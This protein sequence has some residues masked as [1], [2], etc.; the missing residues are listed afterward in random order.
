MS[1]PVARV[2]HSTP[3]RSVASLLWVGPWGVD[4]MT[5]FVQHSYDEFCVELVA[6]HCLS[7]SFYFCSSLVSLY[8][9][10]LFAFTNH[11]LCA[12]LFFST[13]RS[14]AFRQGG[15][16]KSA[17]SALCCVRAGARPQPKYT[18]MSAV[19]ADVPVIAWLR[20]ELRMCFI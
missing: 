16:V 4:N 8:Y 6:L 7:V 3:H 5:I 20:I 14:L 17:Y 13:S 2:L 19:S 11:E 12:K 18:L 9:A 15:F 1:S 10:V